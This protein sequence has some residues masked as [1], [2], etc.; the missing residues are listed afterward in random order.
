M[1][2]VVIVD[3]T[4]KI[5]PDI[6][7]NIPDEQVNNLLVYLQGGP[8]PPIPPTPSPN[9][10]ARVIA[11]RGINL[12]PNIVSTSQPVG[13]LYAKSVVEI[14]QWGSGWAKIAGYCSNS[15]DLLKLIP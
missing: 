4:G 9:M 12:H 15:P 2:T 5:P 13:V 8:L 11:E 3:D 1:R 6:L 14:I 7:Y 10:I